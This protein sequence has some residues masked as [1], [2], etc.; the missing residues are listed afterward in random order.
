MLRWF[1]HWLCL[2]FQN[3]F[4]PQGMCFNV[5]CFIPRKVTSVTTAQEETTIIIIRIFVAPYVH[6]HGA[7]QLNFQDQKLSIKNDV[8]NKTQINKSTN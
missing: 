1:S 7:F 6:A 2:V 5:L 4:N 3:N 8:N